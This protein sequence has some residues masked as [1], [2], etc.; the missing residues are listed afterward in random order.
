MAFINYDKDYSNSGTFIG[1]SVLLL[2]ILIIYI[3]GRA[4][5]NQIAGLY[6]VKRLVYACVL[7]SSYER[8]GYVGIIITME[9]LF[10]VARSVIE[11][12]RERWMLVSLWVE[13]GLI[14]VF[15]IILFTTTNASVVSILTTIFVYGWLLT[16][17]ADLSDLYFLSK[18]KY[19]EISCFKKLFQE[20]HQQFQSTSSKE[21]T[22][23]QISLNH[24][25]Q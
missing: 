18:N 2:T 24:K 25:E 15:L 14:I 19:L 8:T 10:G 3:I 7:A 12:P 4:Y 13:E 1:L 23:R 6:M 16:F 9:G 22:D 21:E 11:K 20:E 17:V 5:F